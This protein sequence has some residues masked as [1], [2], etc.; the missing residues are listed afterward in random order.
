VGFLVPVDNP[1]SSSVLVVATSVGLDVMMGFLRVLVAVSSSELAGSDSVSEDT[2]LAVEECW[3]ASASASSK[4]VTSISPSVRLFYGFSFWGNP[5][6]I[7][8]SLGVAYK[9]QP[10]VTILPWC[11]KLCN[12]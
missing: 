11:G 3:T 12:R 7:C 2:G 8:C 6:V 1:I 10:K 9:T 5:A 4:D